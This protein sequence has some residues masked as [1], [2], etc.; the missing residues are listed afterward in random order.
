MSHPPLDAINLVGSRRVAAVSMFTA[1]AVATDYAMLPLA[2]VKLMDS[3]V[4]VCALTF[5]AEA[6]ASVAGLTWLVYGTVN[7]LGADSASFL[8]LLI[9]SEMVYV[10]FGCLARRMLNPHQRVPTRSLLWGSFGLIATFLYDVNTI[11]TPY[12]VIGQSAPVI[13][14][15]MPFAA[16]FMLTHELSNFLFFS[17]LAPVLYLASRRVAL[18]ASYSRGQ[19]AGPNPTTSDIA[20]TL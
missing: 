20:P 4:F 18:R 2:N 12:L 14:L 10:L 17:T 7:P 3:I 15:E 16:P 6:G 1:L 19:P 8:I 9:L 5:G 11:V 13:L